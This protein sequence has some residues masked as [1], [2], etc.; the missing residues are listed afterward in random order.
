MIV[1]NG[2]ASG[3]TSAL[4]VGLHQLVAV[5]TPTNPAA[6]SPSTSP[7][8][9]FEVTESPALTQLQACLTA[10]ENCQPRASWRG[11]DSPASSRDVPAVPAVPAVT[12]G[13]D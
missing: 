2:A 11:L 3:F 7:T 9:T 6:L 10:I 13:S 12:A 5:F 8:V 1:T 4:P